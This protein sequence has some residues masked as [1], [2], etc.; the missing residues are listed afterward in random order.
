MA[1][2]T[3]GND[4]LQSG[5]CSLPNLMLM[6]DGAYTFTRG[7]ARFHRA[8]APSDIELKH[9]LDTL[10]RRITRALV[11]AG[12]LVEDPQQPWL[13]IH[14]DTDGDSALVQLVGAA[15]RYRIAVGPIAGRKT[16]TLHDPSAV[17]FEPV[18]AKALT[19]ARDGFSLNAA[20]ACETHQRDKLER[21][22][23]YVSRGPI[24]LDRLSLDGD[25]LVVYELKHPF[26]DGTTHVLFEPLDFIARLA[27][28]VPRPRAHL[29][30]YH[31]LFAP[32]ANHRQHIVTGPSS[33]APQDR[34]QCPTG[35]THEPK[36]TAPMS[37][38][39]RLRRVFEIDLRFCPRCGGHMRVIADITEPTLIA[40]I[41]AHRDARDEFTG[42]APVGV[43]RAPPAV[44]L[45]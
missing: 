4:A 19:T 36:P 12:V 25:G 22:C 5:R 17:S 14:P 39:Q 18:P 2:C 9:L 11:R 26:R 45:H 1:H 27:A 31:G 6:P 37:W 10:I 30:R 13:D 33:T 32:N 41:L 7:Q 43:A 21:L 20:V 16:M 8:P 24:A 34:G 23:R 28:L 42:E 38:I 35:E 40:R 29:V 44:S 15:V 3:G